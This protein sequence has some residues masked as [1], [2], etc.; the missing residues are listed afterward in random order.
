[1]NTTLPMK[2]SARTPASVAA[3]PVLP[4]PSDPERSPRE[5]G[6]ILFRHKGKALAFILATVITA[7]VFSINQPATYTAEALLLLRQGRDSVS[8]DPTATTGEVFPMRKDWDSTLNSELAILNSLAMAEAVVERLGEEAFQ[9]APPS[10]TRHLK[11]LTDLVHADRLYN[12]VEK[13]IKRVSPGRRNRDMPAKWILSKGLRIE[14]IPDSDVIRIACTLDSPETARDAV[15]AL[16]DLYE[17]KHIAVHRTAGSVDFFSNQ[18]T[19]LGEKLHEAETDLSKKKNELGT[20]NPE[21]LRESA[22]RRISTLREQQDSVQ[23]ERAAA[24]TGYES[25]QRNI[26]TMSNSKKAV[27]PDAI[28]VLQ[29]ELQTTETRLRTLVRTEMTLKDQIKS[30]M[31]EVERLNDGESE[32]RGMERDVRILEQKY[33]KYSEHL[34]QARIDDALKNAM[35]SNVSVIQDPALPDHANETH[36]RFILMLALLMGGGGGIGIAFMSERIDQTIRTPSD[37]EEK[38]NIRMLGSIPRLSHRHIRPRR[39]K[40]WAKRHGLQELRPSPDDAA[41]PFASLARRALSAIDDD[42]AEHPI[43]VGVTSCYHGEGTS[44]IATNLAIALTAARPDLGR[45]LLVEPNTIHTGSFPFLSRTD[46]P[47]ATEYI[48]SGN[49]K[50][51]VSEQNVYALGEDDDRETENGHSSTLEEMVA[52]ARTCNADV[53]VFDIPPLFDGDPAERLVPLMDCLVLVVESERTRWQSLQKA[54]HML[55]DTK[56]TLLGAVLNK[57][58]YHVPSWLYERL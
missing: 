45:V 40:R 17:D 27:S 39:Q 37:L 53:A 55:T 56:A 8:L 29:A 16:L 43:L 44:T 14:L 34:E 23:L 42:T 58:R 3:P 18:I 21:S 31:T 12:A 48:R 15:A 9:S 4:A 6:R 35:I 49:G 13:M 7:A 2:T 25:L 54:N 57:R 22:S 46:S 52:R 36:T 10:R 24:Q 20:A 28:R 19:A 32:L 51:S 1:M 30:A 41:V 38:L 47:R 50:T 26:N 33:L 5:I 11:R